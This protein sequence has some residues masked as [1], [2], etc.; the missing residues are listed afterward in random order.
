MLN[1]LPLL[2]H[3]CAQGEPNSYRCVLLRA[4]AEERRMHNWLVFYHALPGKMAFIYDIA[5]EF[6][7]LLG[8]K[9]NSPGTI[10]TLRAFDTFLRG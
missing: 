7:A 10:S 3:S 5:S 1:N 8:M 6:R 2:P 9:K 4:M